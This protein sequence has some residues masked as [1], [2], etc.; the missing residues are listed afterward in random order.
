MHSL[1]LR[2]SSSGISR[3]KVDI[4]PEGG[5]WDTQLCLNTASSLELLFYAGPGI[6]SNLCKLVAFDLTHAASVTIIPM[7]NG[8]CVNVTNAGDVSSTNFCLVSLMFGF[9]SSSGDQSHTLLHRLKRFLTCSICGEL[10][11]V[12]EPEQGREQLQLLVVRHCGLRLCNCRCAAYGI[13]A[14]PAFHLLPTLVHQK[15]SSR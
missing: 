3:S 4:M 15:T 12:G 9:R 6:P 1:M 2:S 7:A 14:C 8:T 11:C 13:R 5:V 10:R